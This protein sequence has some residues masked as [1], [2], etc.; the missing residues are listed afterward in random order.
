MRLHTGGWRLCVMGAAATIALSGSAPLGQTRTAGAPPP[1]PAD[2]RRIPAS[3]GD[4][5][6]VDGDARLRVIRQR[7]AVI[8]TIFNQDQRWLLVLADFAEAGGSAD[9][10]VDRSYNFRDIKDPWP[11]M[12]RW[13]GEAVIEEYWAVDRPGRGTGLRLPN[14]LVQLLGSP[15]S[16]EFKDPSAVAVLT[17]TGSGFGGVDRA[18]FDVAEQRALA[19]IARNVQ[20]RGQL[21]ANVERTVSGSFTTSTMLEGGVS[22][23]VVSR[24]E[25]AGPA[26][27]RV[28]GPIVTP[29][30]THYVAPVAPPTAVQA[31]VVG[32]V[33]LEVTVDTDGR[34]RSARVL[35]SIPLLDAA[36]LDAVRQ[37]RYEPT[38]LQGTP[39]PVILTVP[40]TVQ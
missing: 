17:H 2:A 25:S 37:W 10:L 7:P 40:V 22:G 34:I 38:L 32:T 26:P 35:R 3:D 20:M 13:Q 15:G 36:A 19:D 12:D 27:V 11:F 23:V 29:K 16:D 14:G 1:F 4:L 5:I 31:G 30:R 8:R 6:V 39:V 9:G 33:I 18:P 24:N 28:G 21:P